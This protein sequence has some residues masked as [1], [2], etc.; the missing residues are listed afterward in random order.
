MNR[1]NFKVRHAAAAII[2]LAGYS[3]TAEAQFR[4]CNQA[5]FTIN[6]AMVYQEAD[7]SWP[8]QG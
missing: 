6:V 7:G 8:S 5:S 4:L 2:F 1:F 3:T